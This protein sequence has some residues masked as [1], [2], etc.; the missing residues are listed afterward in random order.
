MPSLEPHKLSIIALV[1]PTF[2]LDTQLADN[3]SSVKAPDKLAAPR[4]TLTSSRRLR[5]T[6]PPPRQVNELSDTHIPPSQLVH[7][8]LAP[9]LH[10]PA[11]I[12]APN[13][14]NRTDPVLAR[15]ALR[16]PPNDTPCAVKP[17]LALLASLPTLNTTRPLP[18][19]PRPLEHATP[20][21]ETHLELSHPDRPTNPLPLRSHI[22]AP[23]PNTV[24]LADPDRAELPPPSP[25]K[26]TPPALKTP[27]ALPTNPPTV[28]PT[29]WLPPPPPPRRHAK[30]LCDAHLEP[31]QPESPALDLELRPHAPIPLPT[32]VAIT[33]PLAALFPLNTP[34]IRLASHDCAPH[35]LP[36]SPPALKITLLLL[37]VPLPTRHDRLLSDVHPDASQELSPSLEPELRLTPP[38]LPPSKVMLTLP[39]TAAFTT[40]TPLNAPREADKPQDTLE[41]LIPELT[42]HLPLARV[43]LAARHSTELSDTHVDLS[44]PLKPDRTAPLTDQ[45]PTN[46]PNTLTPTLPVAPEFHPP[47]ALQDP[48]CT[49]YRLLALPTR[50]A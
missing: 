35:T 43:R 47:K 41:V 37:S 25:L 28:T 17:T 38:K 20:L 39:V 15:F 16:T 5:A 12:R 23:H 49:E 21:S 8:A 34:L 31:W 42:I 36:D 4:S 29:P 13:S 19:D 18:L 32:S 6:A 50:L 44:H 24:K 3:T 7:P 10:R 1:D 14:V 9:T 48:S 11:P 27:V 40:L 46:P 2:P 45:P 22:P 30:E 26:I 33:L